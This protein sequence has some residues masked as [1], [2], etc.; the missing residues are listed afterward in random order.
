M[1]YK[2]INKDKV[3]ELHL[4]ELDEALKLNLAY[5][6]GGMSIDEYLNYIKK[7]NI[8]LVLE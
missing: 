7:N 4:E 3:E 6:P 8:V 2:I 5:I 1:K